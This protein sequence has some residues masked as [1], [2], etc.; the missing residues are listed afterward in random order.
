M[1]SLIHTPARLQIISLL[2]TATEAEFAFVRDSLNMSDSVVSKHAGALEKAGYIEI[3]KGYVGK[4]PRT[5][6]KLTKEGR[7]AFDD[8]ITTLQ[9][10]VGRPLTATPQTDH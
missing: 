1:A 4:R 10:I 5:W 7:H 9:Q 3:R 2:A 8:Y 6:F